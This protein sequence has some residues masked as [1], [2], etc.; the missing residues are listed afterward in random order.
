MKNKKFYIFIGTTAELIKLIPVIN[1]FRQRK[2]D[3]KII[4][5]GQNEVDFKEF[6]NLLGTVKVDI[7]IP[8]KSR[9]SS[10]FYF[11]L[12]AIATLI[13]GIVRL[14]REFK[15]E[16]V[17]LIVHGDTVSSLIGALVGSFYNV[18]LVH[19][20]S[21]LRS[22]NFLEPFP[23]EISRIAVTKLADICFCPNKWSMRNLKNIKGEKLNTKQNTLIESYQLTK[24]V[25]KLPDIVKK[26]RS[27]RKKYFVLVIHR[28]EHV[29]FKRE[30]TAD[31][32]NF[33]LKNRPQDLA[34]V[35]I[36]H[37]I[38]ES[39]LKT[40]GVKLTGENIIKV[41]RLPYTDFIKLVEKSEFIVT[42]GGSNQEEAYYMGKPCLVVRGVTERIEGIGENAVLYGGKRSTVRKFLANY[43]NYKRQNVSYKVAPSEVIMQYLTSV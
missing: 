7:E 21:G 33:I 8:H 13:R 36:V 39:F 20:E 43:K 9:K 25:N 26:L 31:L 18:K 27:R 5:S 23:E 19:I 28:Q 1:G 41:P 11:S 14:D 2:I 16:G 10:I 35:F 15:S 32:I 37:K 24:R 42:D 30:K 22:F 12:W 34:C 29:L 40:S 17:Y 38:T 3:L 6:E 4:T